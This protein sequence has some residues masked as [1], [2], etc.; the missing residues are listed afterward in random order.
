VWE[1]KDALK[2]TLLSSGTRYP[3]SG[4][5]PIGDY[6]VFGKSSTVSLSATYSG[7]T[8]NLGS[9]YNFILSV[10]STSYST[11]VYETDKKSGAIIS[12]RTAFSGVSAVGLTV[13]GIITSSSSV[14]VSALYLTSSGAFDI[15]QL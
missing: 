13:G 11:G 7:G 3:A 9:A 8:A 1:D 2:K 6:M 4:F 14:S 15:Y 10:R 5:L 12:Y